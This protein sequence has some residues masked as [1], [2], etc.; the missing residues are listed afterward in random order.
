[1]AKPRRKRIFFVDDEPHVCSAVQ[2]VLE[3]V[4]HEVRCFTEARKCLVA[5]DRGLCDLLITDVNMP[6]MDGIE[7]LRR[8]REIRPR[9]QMLV[10]TGYGDIP[11][12]VRAVKAGAYDF[13]EK[14][15]ETEPLLA[16]VDSG[17]EEASKYGL[18]S[19]RALTKAERNV[20]KY[21]L[22]GMGNS[23]IAHHL[24]RSIRTI[25]DHRYRIMRKLGVDNMVELIKVG[26]QMD[27]S[28]RAAGFV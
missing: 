28:E 11:L 1:M 6:E 25:E 9:L 22:R 20:L 12:A 15:L 21:L 4:G 16:A 23:D 26:E 10:V 7:L 2:M 13:V 5:M 14:P 19:S 3:R 17:L 18:Q 24:H 8:A 27:L